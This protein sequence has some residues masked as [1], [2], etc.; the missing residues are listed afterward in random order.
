MSL[1]RRA[2]SPTCT[3]T[4]SRSP[5]P[6]TATKTE[7]DQVEILSVTNGSRKSARRWPQVAWQ[8][9]SVPGQEDAKPGLIIIEPRWSEEWKDATPD[10]FDGVLYLLPQDPYSAVTQEEKEDLFLLADRYTPVW[11]YGLH[12]TRYVLQNGE[13]KTIVEAAVRRRLEMEREEA[14]QHE[15]H[16][17]D[18]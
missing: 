4:R 16:I 3:S 2:H 1:S 14:Q 17:P 13:P 18:V 12:R 8:A 10:M 11:S 5:P 9:P 6:V 7:T 15:D